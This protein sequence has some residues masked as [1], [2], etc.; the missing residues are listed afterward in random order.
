MRAKINAGGHDSLYRMGDFVET[1]LRQVMA[2]L[3][4]NTRQLAAEVSSMPPTHW[5]H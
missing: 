3:M 2:A 4:T 1:M 5:K